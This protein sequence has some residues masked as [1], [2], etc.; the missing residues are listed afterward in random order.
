MI[1]PALAVQLYTVRG[2]LTT[3]T[4]IA[5]T[6][7]QVRKIGYEYVETSELEAVSL[8][9]YAKILDGEGLS[10]CG[11][12]SLIGPLYDETDIIIEKLKMLNCP[13]AVCSFLGDE[14]RSKEGFKKAAGEF[15]EIGERFS[16]AGIGFA[17]HN[18]SFEFE[19][20]GQKTG[21]EIIYDESDP[22]LVKAELDTYWVQH[23]GACPAQW[24]KRMKGRMPLV[25]LKDMAIIENEQAMV[26]VGEG[27]I[28][29][30]FVLKA[31]EESGV[32]HYI[33]EQDYCQRP[34]LDSLKISFDNL[35]QLFAN[36][37]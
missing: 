30:A 11:F 13:H 19:R 26:E 15:N 20:F 37:E 33:V 8:S 5:A 2:L 17:Y 24:C 18:H 10:V 14:Y 21:L 12:H 7:K 27:N 9:E 6:L 36:I 23:G 32:E 25:H 1:T 35:T 4:D 29:W 28:N 16:K 31:C 22:K 3:K 34:P